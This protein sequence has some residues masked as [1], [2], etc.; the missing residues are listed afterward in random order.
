MMWY[1]TLGWIT[2]WCCCCRLLLVAL[3]K[4]SLVS[5]ILWC[6]Q[7]TKQTKPDELIQAPQLLPV[8]S[9]PAKQENTHT[10]WFFHLHKQQ[11]F[12]GHLSSVSFLFHQQN[13][14]TTSSSSPAGKHY[15]YK[16]ILLSFISFLFPI[17]KI[18]FS[19]MHYWILRRMYVFAVRYPFHE[20][21]MNWTC[22]CWFLYQCK[23]DS[24]SVCSSLPMYTFEK[25]F[26]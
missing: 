2:G 8:F 19:R 22:C 18:L 5:W 14:P 11:E 6:E 3:D 16:S 9:S 21:G 25:L 26:A 4:S 1:G 10:P 17:K 13:T 7:T 12:W 23:N 15:K 24:R 20:N